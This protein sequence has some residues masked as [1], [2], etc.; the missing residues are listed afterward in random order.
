MIDPC[1]GARTAPRQGRGESQ[2]DGECAAQSVV[3]LYDVAQSVARLLGLE[4]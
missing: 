1:S 4:C 2:G 3:R